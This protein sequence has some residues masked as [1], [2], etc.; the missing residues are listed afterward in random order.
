MR[1]LLQSGQISITATLIG[2]VSTII[3][4]GLGA[5]GISSR[6]VSDVSA[7]VQVVEERENNHYNEVKGYLERIDAKL[8]RI[9]Q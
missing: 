5:Y 3:V 4:G 7:R 2:A 9:L 1:D 8:D 6:T